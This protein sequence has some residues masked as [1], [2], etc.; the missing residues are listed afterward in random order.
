MD[1]LSKSNMY[2]VYTSTMIE[3]LKSHDFELI[4][5]F[6]SPVSRS[7]DPRSFSRI[8]SEKL[9]QRFRRNS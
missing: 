2:Q 4:L 3:N 8:H 6:L 5:T 1:K 7:R 9:G